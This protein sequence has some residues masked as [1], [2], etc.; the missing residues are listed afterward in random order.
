[1]TTSMK[2]HVSRPGFHPV[3]IWLTALFVTVFLSFSNT[4]AQGLSSGPAMMPTL[5]KTPAP[6]GPDA[7]IA[8]AGAAAPDQAS[9]IAFQVL[10]EREA[11]LSSQMMA[12]VHSVA[13]KLGDKVS[14][15]DTLITFDC[16]ELQARRA[17]GVAEQVAAQ[18]THLSKLRLQGLGAA[19]ELEVA[20][21]ASGLVRALANVG[22][23]DAQMINCKLVA[24]FS[25]SVSRLRVKEQEVVAPNQAVVDL[26]DTENLKL[27][28]YVPA[29]MSRRITLE[30]ML[31]VWVNDESRQRLAR[32][33]RINPRID[34][35]SQ[36]LEIEAVLVKPAPGLKPGMLGNAQLLSPQRARPAKPEPSASRR[37]SVQ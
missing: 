30:S 26:V 29:S 4:Q 27:Q 12:R 17:S 3:K 16:Q 37:P 5:P 18:D 36:V 31:S 6:L 9:T 11:V 28:L 13:F 1:M 2:I 14:Q 25:G 34:G 32:V 35:S 24:P 8:G 19:G 23:I 15:G 33:S 10:P 21:A 22:Q 7:G 20:L